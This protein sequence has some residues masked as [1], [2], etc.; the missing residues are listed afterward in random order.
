MEMAIKLQWNGKENRLY[1][2][3]RMKLNFKS[4]KEGIAIEFI[5]NAIIHK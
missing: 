3:L 4:N 2:A 5:F 1:N